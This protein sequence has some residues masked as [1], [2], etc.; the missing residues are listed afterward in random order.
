MSLE[1]DEAAEWNDDLDVSP[2]DPLNI[3][4]VEVYN[5]LNLQM[6]LSNSDCILV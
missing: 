4:P 5:F 6:I 1:N 3:L 2:Q